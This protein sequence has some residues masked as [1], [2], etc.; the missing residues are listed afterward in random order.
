VDASS[1]EVIV[2]LRDDRFVSAVRALI[3]TA[4]RYAGCPSAPA[5]QNARDVEAAIHSSFDEGRVAE[6]LPVT[7]RRADGPLEVLVNGQVFRLD[8]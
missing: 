6:V 1:F 4:A 3:D 7:V 5:A 2:S 8:V